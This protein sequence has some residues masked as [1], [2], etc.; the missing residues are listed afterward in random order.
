M[1]AATRRLSIVQLGDSIASGE[2]TLYGYRYDTRTRTWMGGRID[3]AWPGPDPACHVSPDGYGNTVAQ[4]LGARFT[5]FAC[6]G[7]SYANGI[8]APE[9][10]SGTLGTTELRPAQFGDYA[11]GTDLNAA[12]D[13][14][15]PDVALLTLGADDLHFVPVVKDCVE[16]AL[17]TRVGLDTLRRTAANP[18]PTIATDV[19]DALATLGPNLRALL[20]AIRGRGRVA[21]HVPKVVV[22]AYHDPLPSPSTRRC[23]DVNLLEPAQ[24]AYL[25]G[26]R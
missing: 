17:A 23:P 24:V 15:K 7:A 6:T 5:T 8:I 11:T 21:G 18:G 1:A 14:A 22:T 19:Q 3:V 13:A 20:G 4:R 2:G 16:N 25:S 9:T 10:D 12:Y 26:L